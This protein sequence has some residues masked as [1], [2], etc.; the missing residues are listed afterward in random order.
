MKSS[1]IYL[2]KKKQK[3]KNGSSILLKHRK[4]LLTENKR[5][6]KMPCNLLYNMLNGFSK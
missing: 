1:Q 6:M 2:A 5:S 4:K 3:E